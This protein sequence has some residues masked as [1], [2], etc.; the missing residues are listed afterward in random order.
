MIPYGI[1]YQF[2]MAFKEANYV[3]NWEEGKLY[4]FRV[5]VLSAKRKFIKS[6]D[7]F[8]ELHGLVKGYLDYDGEYTEEFFKALMSQDFE[9]IFAEMDTDY[10]AGNKKA[11]A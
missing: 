9:S 3:L 7:D 4:N 10:E 6:P 8:V 1:W 2:F 5:F 11:A